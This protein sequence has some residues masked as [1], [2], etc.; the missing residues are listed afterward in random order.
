MKDYQ[1]KL[2]QAT[3]PA[4]APAF[5]TRKGRGDKEYVISSPY[6]VGKVFEFYENIFTGI[7]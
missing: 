5:R 3:Q 7:K 6:N 4:F 2:S 1:N